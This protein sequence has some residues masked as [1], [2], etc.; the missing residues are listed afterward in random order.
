MI[1]RGKTR[2]GGGSILLAYLWQLQL[3]TFVST[4]SFHQGLYTLNSRIILVSGQLWSLST[5]T[6]QVRIRVQ[7]NTIL[8]AKTLVRKDV[9]SSSASSESSA[10]SKDS[11]PAPHHQQAASTDTDV[12]ANGEGKKEK[13]DDGD[14]SSKAQIM[15]L[16]TTDVDRVSEFSWHLFTLIGQSTHLTHLSS[17]ISD[18]H[19][20]LFRSCIM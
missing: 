19:C 14:F 5:T 2:P 7:L 16:M 4:S 3:C 20:A 8:F 11:T 15:T 10:D 6:L 17:S 12:S 13:D 9:A 1:R 18:I